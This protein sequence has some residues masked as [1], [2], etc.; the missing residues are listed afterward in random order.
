[1][2]LEPV[3]MRPADGRE[4]QRVRLGRDNVVQTWINLHGRFPSTLNHQPFLRLRGHDAV[5]ASVNGHRFGV[6]DGVEQIRS[7][8]SDS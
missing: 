6:A 7:R 8:M 5:K 3:E 4:E 1:M 2:G